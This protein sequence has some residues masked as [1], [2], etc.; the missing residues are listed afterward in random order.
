MFNPHRAIFAAGAA[1]PLA[2]VAG[3]FDLLTSTWAY[4]LPQAEL[5]I[6]RF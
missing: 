3:S 2:A 1:A 5:L 4:G 6:S